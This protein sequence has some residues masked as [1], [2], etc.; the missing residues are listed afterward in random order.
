MS[1]LR[2]LFSRA[3]FLVLFCLPLGCASEPGDGGGSQP[4]PDEWVDPTPDGAADIAAGPDIATAPD[5]I[6]STPC[7]TQEDC[8][9]LNT[10]TCQVA[11]CDV[12]AGTCIVGPDKNYTPCDDEDACTSDE[13]C[14]DGVCARG[15]QQICDDGN[16]CTTDTCEA[17]DGCS[18]EANEVPCD[19]GNG[20]T[21]DDTCQAGA[22]E[23]AGAPARPRACTRVHRTKQGWEGWEGWEQ[24]VFAR[25]LASQPL[26]GGWEGWEARVGNAR[27]R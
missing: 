26:F 22:C 13:V 11:L 6:V 4:Q 19:D 18:F 23:G 15:V 17:S 3:A 16:L 24:A 7:T 1:A 12:T 2:P 14:F 20:C 27:R 8:A 5:A 25:L 9:A 21:T 10:D